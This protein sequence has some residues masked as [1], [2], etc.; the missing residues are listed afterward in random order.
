MTRKKTNKE[1]IQQV[2]S[3]VGDEYTF[4]VPYKGANNKIP[5]FHKDCGKVSYITPHNFLDGQRCPNHR[6]ERIQLNISRKYNNE[7]FINKVKYL[8]HGEYTFLQPY[9]NAKE[10]L[11]VRHNVCGSIYKVTPSDF[12]AGRRC[13]NCAKEKRRQKRVKSQEQ[14]QQ[15]VSDLGKVK[16]QLVGQYVN[17]RTPVAIKHLVCGKIINMAPS[18]FIR[19]SRCTCKRHYI[20][21]DLIEDVLTLWNIKYVKY[22]KF[23][24][25]HMPGSKHPQHLDFYLPEYNLAIEYDGEQHVNVKKRWYSPI[26]VARDRNKDKLLKE[27]G[28]KL[29][30]I[31]YKVRTRKGIEKEINKIL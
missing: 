27:H 28:I 30:R 7:W 25:L 12:L 22:K 5:Y 16:Y 4:L 6:Y 20:G 1:F 24:W 21:E 9:H 19:G 31:P 13:P 2:Y 10:K 26:V 15:Q 17:W 8:T 14:F 18:S 3:L 11:S 29:L 23:D